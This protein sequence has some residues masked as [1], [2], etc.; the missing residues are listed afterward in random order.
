MTKVDNDG[1]ISDGMR[2]YSFVITKIEDEAGNSISQDVNNPIKT[3]NYNVYAN[4]DTSLQITL[5]ENDL[6]T[7]NIANG[8]VKNLSVSIEDSHGNIV[9]P[10]TDI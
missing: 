2:T 7:T 9:I 3:Y 8:E 6:N 1:N 4:V 10:V 5:A